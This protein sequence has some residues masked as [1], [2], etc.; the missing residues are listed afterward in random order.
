MQVLLYQIQQS[1]NLGMI[2]RTAVGLN[3]KKIYL[4]DPKDLLTKKIKQITNTSQG[5]ISNIELI[6]LENLE[7]FL[8]QY[9]GRK[10]ASVCNDDNSIE[11]EKF[12]PKESDLIIFGNERGLPKE[13]IKHCEIQIT[14]PM[15]NKLNSLNIACAFSIIAYNVQT[16]L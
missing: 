11:L 2:I 16:K 7:E 13:I 3:I 6:V 12:T 4:T 8:K 14:I 10:I 1:K 9:S 5:T 15:S